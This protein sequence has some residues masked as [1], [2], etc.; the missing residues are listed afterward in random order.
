MEDFEAFSMDIRAAHKSIRINPPE[1]GLN[2]ITCDETVYSYSV[3]PFG[4]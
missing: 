2:L 4:V 3:C 1:Q